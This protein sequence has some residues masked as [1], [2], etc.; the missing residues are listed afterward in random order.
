MM[1]NED[2]HLKKDSPSRHAFFQSHHYLEGKDGV[3]ERAEDLDCCH[4]LIHRS[5][6][7]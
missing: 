7:Q 2:L 6:S 5:C 3:E 4:D 1:L